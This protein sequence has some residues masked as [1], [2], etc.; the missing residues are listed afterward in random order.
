MSMHGLISCSH[1]SSGGPDLNYLYAA[2]RSDVPV[3]IFQSK[4]TKIVKR[5]RKSDNSRQ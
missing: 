5:G 1:H 3:P 2:E 4:K